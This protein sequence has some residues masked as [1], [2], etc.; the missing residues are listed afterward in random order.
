ME[1]M[2]AKKSMFT[3][4]PTMNLQFYVRHF[5][6]HDKYPQHSLSMAMFNL[7]FRKNLE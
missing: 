7:V 6:I 4:L 1:L 2:N 3:H 5:S